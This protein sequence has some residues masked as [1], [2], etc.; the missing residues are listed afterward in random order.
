[1]PRRPEIRSY[2]IGTVGPGGGHQE[3]RILMT[4]SRFHQ[5]SPQILAQRMSEFGTIYIYIYI[6]IFIRI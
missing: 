5:G 3:R 2:Q 1:M 4:S 6:Y